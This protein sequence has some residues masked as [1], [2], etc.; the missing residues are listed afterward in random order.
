MAAVVEKERGQIDES[1]EPRISNLQADLV[2]ALLSAN[3]FGRFIRATNFLVNDIWI[4]I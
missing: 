2:E 1:S 3:P 4:L